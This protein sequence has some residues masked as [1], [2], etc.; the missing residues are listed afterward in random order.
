MGSIG[1]FI[2]VI[3]TSGTAGY[4]VREV[5]KVVIVWLKNQRSEVTVRIKGKNEIE[6]SSSQAKEGSI[7]DLLGAIEAQIALS[8]GGHQENEV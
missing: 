3:A 6:I 2:A 4:T 7:E 5:G 1:D 8:E